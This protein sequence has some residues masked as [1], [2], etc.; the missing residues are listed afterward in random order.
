MVIWLTVDCPN[1][2]APV[3]A[4]PPIIKVPEVTAVPKVEL[5]VDEPL[6]LIPPVIV[7]EVDNTTPPEPVSVLKSVNP[8][9]QS[10]A[11]V[12]VVPIHTTFAVRP[13]RIVITK[14]PPDELTVKESEELLQILKVQPNCKV[15]VT[16]N[17]T[18]CAKVPVNNWKELLVLVSVVVPVAVAV[19]VNPV[20]LV[21]P[22]LAVVAPVPPLAI[23]VVLAAKLSIPF[24]LHS[25]VLNVKLSINKD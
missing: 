16:G 7:G 22:P 12:S 20:K 3:P 5:L 11:V 23:G 19:V 13:A 24:C 4:V 6:K 25:F 9:S 21:N 8:N 10:A 14:L 17:T 1:V 15:L 2:I 18:V